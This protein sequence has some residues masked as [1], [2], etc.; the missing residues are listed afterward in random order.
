MKI[1]LDFYSEKMVAY[2][3][4]YA[5]GKLVLLSPWPKAFVMNN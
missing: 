2:L 1:K 3:N 5:T 4:N